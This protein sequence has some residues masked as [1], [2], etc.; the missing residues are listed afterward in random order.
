MKK[1]TIITMAASLF[2]LG[3]A[4]SSAQAQTY[5]PEATLVYPDGLYSSMVP[6]TVDITWDN[7]E[8]SLINSKPND[9]G[10]EYVNCKVTLDGDT[11][12]AP[13]YLVYSY[14]NPDDPEDEDIWQL[15]IALYEVDEVFSFAGNSVELTIPEGVVRNL[16]GN[17]NPAQDFT[18]YITPTFTD[19]SLS[20]PSGSKLSGDD[21]LL[22][23][24]FDNKPI[25]YLQSNVTA[26]IYEPTYK[27]EDLEF[28]KDVQ[29][30]DGNL[31]VIN[32]G[33]L[34]SGEYELLIPEGLL[35]V[36]DGDTK[37][38]CPDIWLE[39]E[40][41]N[42]G[43]P[44]AVVNINAEGKDFEAYSLQGVRLKAKS[45]TELARGIYVVNGKKV[46]IK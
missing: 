23:V 34:A 7:Q 42:S 35:I 10:D 41:D 29:I 27:S 4:A 12:D 14:G 9:W 32:M 44:S 36:T 17:I 46:V 20:M 31:L 1:S 38:I 30:K 19:Y 33:A 21:L 24:S 25:E 45:A 3:A 8:I 5:M 26:Y 11:Y 16:K 22:T 37:Y 15:E 40:V 39:Y 13:A 43:T 6:F 18:F 2:V 28:G